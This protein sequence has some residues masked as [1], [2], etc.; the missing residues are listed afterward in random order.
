VHA[1]ADLPGRDTSPPGR[2]ISIRQDRP[3][4][5]ARLWD[6][7]A[8]CA[9]SLLPSNDA[10]PLKARQR[11]ACASAMVHLSLASDPILAAEQLRSAASALAGVLG[12]NATEAMLDALFGRFCIGK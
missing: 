2:H 1:R 10:L 5:I 9:A 3:E 12:L 11:D 7:I 4:T 8:Q 6:M